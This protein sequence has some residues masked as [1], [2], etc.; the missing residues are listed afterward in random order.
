MVL[1]LV[2]KEVICAMVEQQSKQ[3]QLEEEKESQEENQ[4]QPVKTASVSIKESN[5]SR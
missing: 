1:L 4:E 5:T 2:I 3:L